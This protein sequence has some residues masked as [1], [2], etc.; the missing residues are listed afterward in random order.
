MTQAH[1]G[2]KKRIVAPLDIPQTPIWRNS[3]PLK[4]AVGRMPSIL[5]NIERMKAT[6]GRLKAGR[7]AKEGEEQWRVET[8][9]KLEKRIEVTEKKAKAIAADKK[10]IPIMIAVNGVLDAFFAGLATYAIFNPIKG[11]IDLTVRCAVA[12]GF[13]AAMTRDTVKFI[14]NARMDAADIIF[15]D[16]QGAMFEIE[17]K[18]MMGMLHPDEEALRARQYTNIIELPRDILEQLAMPKTGRQPAK[19]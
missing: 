7:M 4:E 16:Y 17:R 3:I 12:L 19:A 10:Q 9:E 1:F 18:F 2:E 11:M 6:V 13:I 14:R 5:R 8:I 15:R